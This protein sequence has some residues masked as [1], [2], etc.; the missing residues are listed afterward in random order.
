MTYLERQSRFE[1]KRDPSNDCL[2]GPDGCHYDSE[3]EA[4]Y[5]S[6]KASCGCGNPCGVHGFLI[7]CLRQF[8]TDAWPKPGVEGIKKVLLEHPD[9]AAEFIAHYLS[10]EDFTE[11]GG[12]VYGSWITDRGKQFI[13]IGPMVDKDDEP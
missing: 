11:H 12:S 7:Q 1:F 6:L 13:E 4:M 9:I 5:F 10:S 8:E 2:V 3:Q